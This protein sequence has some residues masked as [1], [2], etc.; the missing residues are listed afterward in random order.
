[1]TEAAAEKGYEACRVED[2]LGRSGLSRSTFYLH[3]ADKHECFMAAF[4]RGIDALLGAV[5]EA[6]EGAAEPRAR[7]EAGIGALLSGLTRD[8]AMA[9][10]ALVEIR[11]AGPEGQERYEVA[12]KRFAS[13][14]RTGGCMSP[15]PPGTETERAERTVD[16]VATVLWMEVGAGQT[17]KLPRLSEALVAA[18]RR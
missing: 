14:L 15:G 9:Q 12:S 5:A 2:V 1:M 13:L 3:F 4:E 6:A 8:P 18:V 17:E 11:T 10:V 16:S 7:V